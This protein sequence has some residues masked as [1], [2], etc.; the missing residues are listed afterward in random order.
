MSETIGGRLLVGAAW[1]VLP[2]PLLGLGGSFVPVLRFAQLATGL[3][4]LGLTEG[5][6]GMVGLLVGL[7]WAHAIG[8]GLL[9]WAGV[10]LVRRGLRSALGSGR[11]G[12][13][14]AGLALGV[15]LAGFVFGEYETQFHHSTAHATLAELYR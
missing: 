5:G 10:A 11:V 4:A 15:L 14:L 3:S 6:E 1:L 7:L 8:F 9:V 13:V 2:F 12:P